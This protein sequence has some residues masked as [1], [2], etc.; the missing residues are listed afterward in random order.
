MDTMPERLPYAEDDMI[1]EEGRDW[2]VMNSLCAFAEERQL[3][4]AFKGY[5]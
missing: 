2:V 3:D 5:N 1:G 4:R